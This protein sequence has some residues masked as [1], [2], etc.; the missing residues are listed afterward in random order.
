MG[1]G[2]VTRYLSTY[3]S[4]RVAKA[5]LFG[6]LGPF[7]LQTDDNPEGVP[8]KVFDDIKSA[9][10]QDRFAYHKDFLD[11]FN[12]VDVL[13]DTGRISDRAL[14]NSWNVA[15]AASAIA[16]HDSVDAWLT[17]FRGDVQ[18]LASVPLLI[19]QG[20]EDRILPPAATGRRLPALLPDAQHHEIEGG[21]HNIGWTHADQLNPIFAEFLRQ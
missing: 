12:N 21:P 2:E 17:D 20:S 9:I 11:Q 6:P 15:C 13:G 8:S 18:A 19:V 5:A 16:T 4:R 14:Q 7:L 10:L 1:T 3:G